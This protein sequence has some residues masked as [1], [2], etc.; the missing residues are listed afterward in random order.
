ML[1]GPKKGRIL[2]VTLRGRG[3]TNRP[4]APD[5]LALQLTVTIPSTEDQTQRLRLVGA[6]VENA[7]QAGD[8][9]HVS[10]QRLAFP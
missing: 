1:C 6:D 8:P 7:V 10:Q 3:R 5:K 9:H 4:A 2:L